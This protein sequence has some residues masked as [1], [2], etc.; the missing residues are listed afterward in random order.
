[1]RATSD[2]RGVQPTRLAVGPSELAVVP[3]TA[4]G[5][6]PALSPATE[7]FVVWTQ[8][9][10]GITRESS[11]MKRSQSKRVCAAA[12]TEARRC[13][14]IEAKSV[15]APSCLDCALGGVSLLARLAPPCSG[16][17]SPSWP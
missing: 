7:A 12:V 15:K 9:P 5:S 14:L 13:S 16:G 8:L 1:M 10:A 17:R 3:S 2:W 11:R 4:G 6:P